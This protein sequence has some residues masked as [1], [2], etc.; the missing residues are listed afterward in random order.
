MVLE[1]AFGSGVYVTVM[2]DGDAWASVGAAGVAN[3]GSTS[4]SG[5]DTVPTGDVAKLV[6]SPMEVIAA[7]Y[8][9]PGV[10]AVMCAE[11]VV[12][13]VVVLDV[14]VVVLVSV[15]LLEVAFALGVKVTVI[16]VGVV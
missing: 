9:S 8:A 16:D 10:R 6:P 11:P 4:V 13:P 2:D 14:A 12:F 7:V 1:T 15:M 3:C 5:A